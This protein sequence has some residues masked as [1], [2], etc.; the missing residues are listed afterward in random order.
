MTKNTK[1][2]PIETEFDLV[3]CLADKLQPEFQT[4]VFV[5][6]F[7]AGYGIADLVFARS[8][9]SKENVLKRKPISNYFA[10]E[11]YL[12]MPENTS[13]S[14][15][16]IASLVHLSP[17]SLRLVVISLVND[18]YLEAV[19]LNTFRKIGY[20]ES[21]VKKLVAIEAKLK[22]WKQGIMQARRYRSFTDEC[23][24]AILARYDKNIDYGYLERCDV[25][26]ILFD[27]NTGD[28]ELKRR[29][30]EGQTLSFYRDETNFFAKELF[31][32]SI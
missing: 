3:T 16:D 14:L 20:I 25:G 18:K 4:D 10:L 5:K 8:F 21:P 31:L 11:L 23:Y 30:A 19:G 28:I 22:D 6:E 1:K 26:L 27:E 24:L 32:A 9:Y 29:P 12:S 13:L 17:S 2:L 15:R 7:S